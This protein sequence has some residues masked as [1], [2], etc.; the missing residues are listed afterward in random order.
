MKELSVFYVLGKRDRSCPCLLTKY[1]RDAINLLI[2]R[3]QDVGIV[4]DQVLLFPQP[5]SSKPYNGFKI[6]ADMKGKC[7]SL[8]NPKFLTCTGLRHEAATLLQ[9]KQ[10]KNI[11]SKENMAN[12]LGHDLHVHE[13]N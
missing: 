3:I 11:T 4:K 7:T 12:H 13:Q 5:D 1:M 6:I 8:K 2:T 9:I 10:T